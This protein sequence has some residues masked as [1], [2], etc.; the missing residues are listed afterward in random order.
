MRTLAVIVLIFITYSLFFLTSSQKITSTKIY[1]SKNLKIK[2]ITGK[3]INKDTSIKVYNM[4][5]LQKSLRHTYNQIYL[6]FLEQFKSYKRTFIIC[7][8][9]LVLLSVVSLVFIKSSFSFITVGINRFIFLVGDTL[10][11]IFSFLSIGSWFFFRH[12]FWQDLGPTVFIIPFGFVII[13]TFALKLYDFNYPIWSSLFKS[14]L[15][16]ILSGV[17]VNL[18]I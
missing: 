1:S 16:P 4:N 2:T 6:I 12:N 7:S 10:L 15:I 3:E 14:F 9:F 11:A 5:D 8:L 18:N 13:S 17:V